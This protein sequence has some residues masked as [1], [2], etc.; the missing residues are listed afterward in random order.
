MTAIWIGSTVSYGARVLVQLT[1]AWVAYQE[2]SSL[3]WA[4]IALAA[5]ALPQ[6]LIGLV[7][8]GVIDRAGARASAAITSE[9]AA[10]TVLV[11]SVALTWTATPPLVVVFLLAILFGTLDTIRRTATGALAFAASS[12]EGRGRA[13]ALVNVGWHIGA[14]VGGVAASP[15]LAQAGEA[16]AL[17][18]A[19]ALLLIAAVAFRQGPNP[20]YVGPRT[21]WRS[22]LGA[23]AHLL[24]HSGRVLG[25]AGIVVVAELLGHS[26]LTLLPGLAASI[27]GSAA[28]TLGLLFAVRSLGAIIALAAMSQISQRREWPALLAA[29]AVFGMGLVGLALAPDVRIAAAAIAVAGGASAC[30]DA[31]SQTL[32]Q[33]AGGD[34]PATAMGIWIFGV[35]S[36]PIGL[37]LLGTLGDRIGAGPAQLV[38]GITLVALALIFRATPFVT[39]EGLMPRRRFDL[40]R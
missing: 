29:P 31:L 10:V 17:V 35:G 9:G 27:S 14:V 36:G 40:D 34:S 4:G 8:S 23:S 1:V 33:R 11:A 26:S 7:A 13:I 21:D 22:A 3:A 19:G 25:L 16:S 28:A 30:C 37:F 6:L 38:A 18:V 15:M 20:R 12:P 32:L 39:Q 24:R 5:L 2:T